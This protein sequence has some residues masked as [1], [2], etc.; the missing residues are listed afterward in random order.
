MGTDVVHGI[1][2]GEAAVGIVPPQKAVASPAE[3]PCF[4]TISDY[5]RQ[6]ESSSGA[7]PASSH[8]SLWL[9][10]LYHQSQNIDQVGNEGIIFVCLFN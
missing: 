4:L 10:S 2:T 9:D 7:S 1:E 8:K 6:S 3:T 5:T